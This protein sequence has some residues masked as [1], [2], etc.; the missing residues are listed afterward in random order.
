MTTAYAWAPITK[1][2]D[3]DDGTVMVYG[4]VSD[5]GI[6]RDFQRMGQAWLDEAMPAWM[7]ESGNIREQH[8]GLRA[9]GV[10]VGLNRGSDGTH[11][12]TAHVV[13]EAAV[14]KVKTKVLKGFSVGIRN[15]QVNFGKADAPN[16]EVVGGQIVEVSLVDRPSNPRSLFTMAK[17]DSAGEL[18]AVEHPTVVEVSALDRLAALL[19]DLA[20]HFTQNGETVTTPVTEPATTETEVAPAPTTVTPVETKTETPDMAAI[21]KAAVAEA[22]TPLKD[23]LTLMKADLAKAL[24]M[25]EAGGPVAMRTASQAAAARGSDAASL[26]AQAADL[27]KQ[28]DDVRREDSTLAQGYRERAAELLRK[29]DA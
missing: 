1:V 12:L 27:L 18:T 17:A 24:A 29:A 9:V 13:D 23:E 6:D 19:P 22:T 11:N 4:P 26:R 10:G 14:K 7:A 20:A 8:D 15:P 5:A 3:Q 25:P 16:G 2:E 28:A 21:V